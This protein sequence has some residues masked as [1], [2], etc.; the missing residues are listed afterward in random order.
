MNQKL[1]MIN[2]INNSCCQT[3]DN[4]YVA[5]KYKLKYIPNDILPSFHVSDSKDFG[6]HFE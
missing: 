5:F 2:F 3:Y 1:V 6:R 4:G